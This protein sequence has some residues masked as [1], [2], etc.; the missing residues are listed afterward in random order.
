MRHSFSLLNIGILIAIIAGS[1][2]LMLNAAYTDSAIFDETAHIVA[3]YTYL[4]HLDYR[5]NPEHPPLVKIIAAIPL[6][7]QKIN[8]PTDKDYW[9]GLNEQ[10]AAGNQFLYESGNNA[11]KIIFSSRIGPVLLTLLLILFIYFWAQKLIGRWWALFPT[12]LFAFSPLVLA[13]GH[14][15]TTDIGA[16]LGIFICIYAFINFLYDQSSKNLFM[17]GLAFGLAQAIKFSSVLLIPYLFLIGVIYSLTIIANKWPLIDSSEKNKII[18]IEIARRLWKTALIMAIGYALIV[19]PLYLLTTW[20]YPVEKQ[21]T[22]TSALIGGFKISQLSDLNIWM[23][24]NKISRPLAEY[25]LGVLMVL[26][27]SAGGNNA[28]FLGELS[29]HGWRYYFPLIYLMKETLPALLVI[30]I[31]LIIGLFGALKATTQKI[32]KLPEKILEYLTIHFTEFSMLTFIIIYWA[33]SIMSPLNIGVRHILPTIPFIYILSAGALK[34]WLSTVPC[35]ISVTPLEKLSNQIRNLFNF[36][37]K[38]F[39][40]I[41]IIIWL[42]S[43]TLL[44]APF[45]LSYYNELAGG[46]LSGYEY[47]T[48]SNFD[49][50]QDLKR[51]KIWVGKNLEPEE[52][53]AVDYFGGGNPRYYLGIQF[54]PWW[55]ARGNPKNDKIQWLAISVNTLQGA[56]AKLTPDFYRNPTDEYRWL[57]NYNN[58]TERA[59]TSIFIYRLR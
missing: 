53:I 41:I 16:S 38:T 30:I 45:F 57:E 27:R 31:G 22:D 26:Q 56:Y 8:F 23:A 17:A 20:N 59:G 33:S 37:T 39:I 36:W 25:S 14:Y 3:G 7:F 42:I 58:P 6:I 34:K 40:I 5:F 24:G 29:S 54:E 21:V 47:A 49:W 10:W 46:R 51:L 13:H 9:N 43:E 44:A 15:V 28:Y 52:K 55:S 32:K 50:G 19:Y 1:A 11:D 35:Q 2:L 18:C 12:F 4:K 48:D